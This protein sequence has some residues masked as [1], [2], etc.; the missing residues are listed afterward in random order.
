MNSAQVADVH[1]AILHLQRLADLFQKRREQL[2][3]SVDLTE[4]Q[5]SVLEEIATEHF[6]PSMFAKQR[7]SSAAAVSKTIRQLVNKSLVVVSLASDDA[8]QRH[9]ELTAKGQRVMA[10]L[11][12]ARQDAIQRV[13][14]KQDAAELSNFNR[15]AGKLGD[16]LD[17]LLSTPAPMSVTG[18]S[19][20]KNTVRQGL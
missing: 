10:E 8:R 19:H 2:A 13:W 4:Q 5:W 9:Y 14:M 7:Q 15:F 3:A 1:E 16:A 18:V 6:M 12:A 20:G 17:A 11:R